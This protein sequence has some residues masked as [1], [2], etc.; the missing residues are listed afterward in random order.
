MGHPAGDPPA[1]AWCDR[2]DA[3]SRG[4]EIQ[5]DF[6]ELRVNNGEH[7]ATA[8]GSVG[9]S[10]SHIVLN[11]EHGGIE[12]NRGSASVPKP[13]APPEPGKAGRALPAPKEKVEPTEN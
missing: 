3:R 10:G 5:T 13:P 9:N 11:N 6:S 1:V 12:I 4:G 7:E 8:T 2:L